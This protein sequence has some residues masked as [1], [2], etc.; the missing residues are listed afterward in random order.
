MITRKNI[1]RNRKTI[2][3]SKCEK[4]EEIQRNDFKNR[5][6]NNSSFVPLSD[7]NINILMKHHGF[8][9]TEEEET[10]KWMDSVIKKRN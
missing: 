3:K 8:I 1:S 2:K 6:I 9:T 4:I 5:F 7:K 10:L